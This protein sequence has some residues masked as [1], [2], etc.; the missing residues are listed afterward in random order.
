MAVFGKETSNIF[1]KLHQ[2]RR[3]VEVSAGMLMRA[4]F[5]NEPYQDAKFRQKLEGDIWN[6]GSPDDP[7]KK[8]LAEF[9]EG[10]EERCFPIVRNKY[11]AVT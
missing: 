8:K 4:A 2:A 11:K 1:L 3:S 6:T 10:I 9:E 5:R 7:I